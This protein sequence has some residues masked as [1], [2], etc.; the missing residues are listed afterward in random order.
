MVSRLLHL[1]LLL[2]L[3]VIQLQKARRCIF[4]IV[5][6]KQTTNMYLGFD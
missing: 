2:H 5:Y 1:L 4:P 3:W 6:S